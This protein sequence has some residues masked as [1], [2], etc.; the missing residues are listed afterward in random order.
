MVKPLATHL[1]LLHYFGI[2]SDVPTAAGL[3]LHLPLGPPREPRRTR[4][5]RERLPPSYTRTASRSATWRRHRSVRSRTDRHPPFA[6]GAGGM[7]RILWVPIRNPAAGQFGKET[8]ARPRDILRRDRHGPAPVSPARGKCSHRPA[9][10]AGW[11]GIVA[12]L[13]RIGRPRITIIV[14]AKRPKEC[15]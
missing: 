1:S 12:G 6:C 14:T 3:P 15:D 9:A 8:A 11:P 5:P 2:A 4:N 13:P 7:S 10:A